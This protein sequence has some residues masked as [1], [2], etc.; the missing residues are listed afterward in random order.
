MN[1][2]RLREA[3]PAVDWDA[4]QGG[5]VKR[6]LNRFERWS[7]AVERVVGRVIRD[8]NLNPLYHTGTITIFLLVLL[9][10][11]GIY[12]TLFYQFG[13][14][15][16][17]DAVAG[18]EA[19]PLSRIVR[20]VHRYASAATLITAVIHAWR[21]FF[22][23]RFRGAR[24]VPWVTGVAMVSLVWMAGVTGYWLI[25][26]VTA[27]PLNQ[28]LI[29][30]VEILPGGDWFII[31]TLHPDFA[32]TGWVFLVLVITAHV[33]V[34]AVI[35]L[36]LWYHLKRLNRARWMP[37]P[38]WMWV[39]VLL[40]VT[41]AVLVPA[42]ML[43]DMDFGSRPDSLTVDAWFLAYV[44]AALRAPAVWWT[45]VLLLAGLAAAIP[46]LL[47]RRVPGPVVVDAERCT[48]CTLC[49]VDCPYSAVTLERKD[50][51][52]LL[53]IIDPRL[54]VSCGVCIGSC[55][56]LAISFDGDPPEAHTPVVG[57]TGATVTYACERHIQQGF[58]DPDGVVVPL[59]C[60]GAVH[61]DEV[62][63]VLEAGAG[64][65]RIVGCPPDDCASREGNEWT[66]ERM[67]RT[68]RPRLDDLVDQDRV[69]M[70]WSAPPGAVGAD[71]AG[72][73]PF[74]ERIG[75]GQWR[76]LVPVAVL[77]GVLMVGQLLLTYLP[78][79]A[80]GSDAAVL[81]VAVQHRRGVP[82]AGPTNP[83]SPF[84]RVNDTLWQQDRAREDGM[85]VEVLVDGVTVLDHTYD[86]ETVSVFEQIEIGSGTHAVRVAVGDAADVPVVLASTLEFTER[87]VVSLTILDQ[88]L[89]ADPARGEELFT[90]AAIRGGAGCRVCHSLRRGD[91]GVAPSLAGIGTRAAERIPGMAS[92]EYLRRSILYPDEYVVEGYRAGQ[93]R[94][95]ELDE[96]D[97]ADL[98]AYLLTLR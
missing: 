17:Y 26:D 3:Q 57:A 42:G 31:N 58:E 80:F 32:G 20:A 14:D 65:V 13:F 38:Q 92:E 64:S 55:P 81:Q 21:T 19:N 40:L 8:H 30:L 48:G 61:P 74:R 2:E 94:P 7:L 23:D 82:I 79:D 68:R 89:A 18:I 76:R 77:I 84:S 59:P 75:P 63:A 41:A 52:D 12:L 47:R 97:L 10:V 4:R 69:E 66:E 43:P 54:C 5:T 86:G 33:L 29:D 36:M 62:R 27:S 9:V 1:L 34:T 24:W 22:M 28:T 16:T 98:I 49:F 6:W 15:A 95:A 50:G 71:L 60:M 73:R 67:L 88:E 87:E 11:T 39:S 45:A 70:I 35:G 90:S 37:P 91:D 25:W 56:P 85:R 53:A 44:P 46:W 78:V 83:T 72:R 93:M 51:G 96:G